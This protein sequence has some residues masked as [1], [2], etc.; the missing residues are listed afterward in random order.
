[1]LFDYIGIHGWDDIEPLILAAVVSDHSVLFIGDIGSNKTEGSKVIAKALLGDNINFRNY[2]VPTLNFD[3]LIGF[4]N[5]KNLAD[6]VLEFVASPLSIWNADAALFDEI[7]RANPFI[8]SKLHE[9]IRT[10][11]LMGLPTQ[12]K[13]VFSAVNPPERYQ[14]GYMDMALASRFICVQVPN[15]TAMKETHIDQIISG[16]GYRPT[17][18]DLKT[19]IQKARRC[20]F[21]KEEINRVH[22]MCKKI[23]TELSGQEII[24]N[25]RQ[26]K[27]MTKMIKAGL[28]LKHASGME[29]FSEPDTIT[30]YISSV[31]PE[32][33]GVVRSNAN[34]GMVQGTIR[35]IVSGFTLGDPVTIAADIKELCE[36]NITDSLAWVS[37]MKQMADQEEDSDTLKQAIKKIKYL[38]RKEVVIT[39]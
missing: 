20:Q 17:P 30:N 33:N 5:P 7:N 18:F 4:V 37:A 35:S 22:Q 2:E 6:G 26:L 27:M 31:I 14:S 38:T 39:V 34:K 1:M 8:Q 23:I 24:F 36:V 13:M 9:L 32:I 19:M 21:S 15:I 10:R 29:R 28:A 16:N 12:L 11:S 3:D 25:A